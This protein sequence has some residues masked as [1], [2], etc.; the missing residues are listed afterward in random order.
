MVVKTRDDVL[1][2]PTVETV[3]E[4][5]IC[6]LCYAPARGVS[7][8][9]NEKAQKLARDAVAVFSGKGVFGVEMFLLQDQSV[10]VNEIAPRPHNSGHYTIEA[11][12]LS[13][14]DVHLRA[15]LDK[16]IPKREL[17]LREPAI[18]LNILGGAT[19]DSHLELARAAEVCS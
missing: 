2:F 16:P 5:S 1:S 4:D 10:L 17:R 15:L 7:Q 13:Q 11:C 19:P 12:P 18:M 9:I 8:A 14:Y 3:H 6:K